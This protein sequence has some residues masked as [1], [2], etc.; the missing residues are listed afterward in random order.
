MVTCRKLYKGLSARKKDLKMTIEISTKSLANI[1]QHNKMGRPILKLKPLE[2][3]GIHVP[4]REE[5]KILMRVFDCQGWKFISGNTPLETDIWNISKQDTVVGA[6]I[7]CYGTTELGYSNRSFLEDD[8]QWKIISPSEFYAAQEPPIT[9]DML[10][11]INNYFNSKPE[12][13]RN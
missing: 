1:L 3:T 5:Y 12:G 10:A 2:N 6:G 7:F 11:E 13:G 9:P 4:T 8:M